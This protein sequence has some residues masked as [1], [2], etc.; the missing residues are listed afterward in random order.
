[1]VIVVLSSLLN[2][3]MLILR[4]LKDNFSMRNVSHIYYI[5]MVLYLEKK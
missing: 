2:E 1:M 4:A 3:Y 5:D